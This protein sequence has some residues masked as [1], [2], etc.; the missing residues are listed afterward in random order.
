[1]A[2][3]K[4]RVT[5]VTYKPK[6]SKFKN[7]MLG[8]KGLPIF[9]ILSFTWGIL[10]SIIGLIMMI[11]F[12]LT[13]KTKVEFGR[14]Y[15]IFPKMFGSSWGFAIGC[16]FFLAHD[17]G[18][19]LFASHECG[20]TVQN[21]MF[22]PLMPFLVSIPSAI[23]FWYRNHAMKRGKDLKPYYDIWFEEQATN[24]GEDMM[25]AWNKW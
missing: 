13:R 8:K 16:F 24:I 25:T 17:S 1:M 12:L 7:F 14:L 15:G 21:I 10:L 23:R 4:E 2:T 9:Y 18:G 20:H 19:E 11:P 3:T 22:G 6:M 5:V